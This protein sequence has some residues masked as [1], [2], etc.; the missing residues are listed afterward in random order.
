MHI[1]EVITCT[2]NTLFQQKVALLHVHLHITEQP[3]PIR[4]TVFVCNHLL[5]VGVI[6][7]HAAGVFIT[8]VG[9]HLQPVIVRISYFALNAFNGYAG[10]IAV[11]AQPFGLGEQLVF[12]VRID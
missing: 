11:L 4:H 2:Q 10:H 12:N 5:A 7:R 1:L 8:A 9:N 6:A 3:R